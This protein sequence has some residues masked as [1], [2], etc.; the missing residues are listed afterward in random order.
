[1]EFLWN[2]NKINQELESYIP[3]I[4]MLDEIKEKKWKTI[5][6]DTRHSIEEEL[7]LFYLY[8]YDF[9]ESKIKFLLGEQKNIVYFN[10]KEKLE[11][12][13]STHNKEAIISLA[14]LERKKMIERLTSIHFNKFFDNVQI[15]RINYTIYDTLM[16]HLSLNGKIKNNIMYQLIKQ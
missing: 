15:N 1:M 13:Q 8:D 7:I 5:L 6:D 12:I 9:N 10:F 4:E 14:L 3:F 16:N 2:K 11:L